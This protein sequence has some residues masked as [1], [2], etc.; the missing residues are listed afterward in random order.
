MD[1]RMVGFAAP[2]SSSRT[3]A[4][5]TPPSARSR[6]LRRWDTSP[7]RSPPRLGRP[8]PRTGPGGGRRA[9]GR[10]Q[11]RLHADPPQGAG[12]GGASTRLLD[13]HGGPRLCYQFDRAAGS[14]GMS[15][16]RLW[17]TVRR[18]PRRGALAELLNYAF[19]YGM[20]RFYRSTTRPRA[21]ARSTLWLF[22]NRGVK[23]SPAISET[24]PR[25]RCMTERELARD[26][27]HQAKVLYIAGAAR[28][29]STVLECCW[30]SWM[31]TWPRRDPQSVGIRPL[32]WLAL[33]LP[34]ADEKL[35]LLA[36]G[37]RAGRA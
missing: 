16:R 11:R 32:G 34:G 7:A 33:R 29:G 30:G 28:S 1:R 12:G 19:H 35:P 2:G 10:R 26:T 13:V 18:E 31:A 17:S 25:R 37:A 27:G 8:A 14:R 22:R 36:V 24:P 9:S 21:P 5:T 23:R 3:V 4:S 15:P 6:L 20:Y